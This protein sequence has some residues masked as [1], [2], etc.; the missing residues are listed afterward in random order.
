MR[1]CLW[2]LRVAVGRYR[3]EWNEGG[4]P[5]EKLGTAALGLVSHPCLEVSGQPP[6]DGALGRGRCLVP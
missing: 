2:V 1:F 4:V 5:L 6:V 3:R